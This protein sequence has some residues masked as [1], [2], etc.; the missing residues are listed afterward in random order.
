MKKLFVIL[1]LISFTGT[2]AQNDLTQLEWLTGNWNRTNAKPGRS[3]V[4]IWRKNSNTE[5]VGKGINLKGTDTVFVEKL[6]IVVKEGAMFY[7]ADVPQNKEPVLFK[8][9]SVTASGVVFENPQH[10]FPK[11]IAYEFDGTKLKATISG[12]GKAIDYWFERK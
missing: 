10:D 3:G 8:A 9:T 12:D 2:F 4:E 6:K 7:V 1:F 5:F 11:K